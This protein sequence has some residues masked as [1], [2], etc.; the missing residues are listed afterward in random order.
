LVLGN[1]LGIIIGKIPD[2]S[3][4]S[5]R[6]SLDIIFSRSTE[7]MFS[8]TQNVRFY[9]WGLDEIEALFPD[10]V[11]ASTLESGKDLKTSSNVVEDS[12]LS[13]IRLCLDYFSRASSIT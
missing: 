1:F 10:P 5:N 8:I 13:N 3:M 6:S 2:Q 4:T 9:E 11:E 12:L 7:H